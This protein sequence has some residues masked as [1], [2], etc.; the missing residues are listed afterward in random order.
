VVLVLLLVQIPGLLP[1][2]FAG[3]AWLD[4]EHRVQLGTGAEGYQLVLKHDANAAPDSAYFYQHQHCV[5]GRMLVALASTK[6]DASQDHV[7][8]FRNTANS[9]NLAQLGLLAGTSEI[10]PRPPAWLLVS[11]RLPEPALVSHQFL[12]SGYSRPPP[13]AATT[14]FVRQTVLLI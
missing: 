13:S 14:A 9:E 8:S 3:L 4:N 5:V 11:Q 1:L 2:A 12:G 10:S 7:L 6:P